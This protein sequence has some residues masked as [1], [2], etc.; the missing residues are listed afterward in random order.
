MDSSVLGSI[1]YAI[2]VLAVPLVVVLGHRGCGA[3]RAGVDTLTNEVVPS[4]YIRA[5]VES[6]TSSILTGR[7]EGLD[8]IEEFETRH[9]EET[10]RLI[11]TRSR[12]VARAVADGSV[13]LVGATY[14]LNEGEVQLCTR[15]SPL[16]PGAA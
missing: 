16:H 3:V 6:V 15:S 2:E 13:E 14:D 7:S 8:T 10:C 12:L 4:G 9:V 11:H 1:E 5:V